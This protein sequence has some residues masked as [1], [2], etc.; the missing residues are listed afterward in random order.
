MFSLTIVIEVD[1]GTERPEALHLHPVHAFRRRGELLRVL[2]RRPSATA[3][4]WP[5]RERSADVYSTVECHQRPRRR[6]ERQEKTNHKLKCIFTLKILRNPQLSS[7]LRRRDRDTEKRTELGAREHTAQHL[8]G[9]KQAQRTRKIRPRLSRLSRAPLSVPWTLEEVDRSGERLERAPP[10]HR[11]GPQGACLTR[12]PVRRMR[13][14]PEAVSTTSLSWPTSSSMTA[15]SN[16]CCMYPA[17]NQP[18]SPPCSAVSQS[19]C[20]RASSPI[21]WVPRSMARFHERSS[22]VASA[23]VR[24]LMTSPSGSL[25]DA[26]R[27]EF[28]CLRRMCVARPMSC[29]RERPSSASSHSRCASSSGRSRAPT[30]PPP[31]RPRVA[32]RPGQGEGQGQLGSGS[33]GLGSEL[34]LG[35]GSGFRQRR[36]HLCRAAVQHERLC[37]GGVADRRRGAFV[38]QD[39]LPVQPAVIVDIALAL[40]DLAASL[41]RGLVLRGGERARHEHEQVALLCVAHAADAVGGDVVG[42]P[43]QAQ[44]RGV[45]QVDPEHGGR[46]L[47]GLGAAEAVREAHA[48]RRD[49]QGRVALR[50]A[51]LLRDLTLEQGALEVLATRPRAAPR[52]HRLRT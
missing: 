33:V 46:E 3:G 22:R 41:L 32:A 14:R 28:W 18:R 27:R 25:H 7:L 45:T 6:E 16:S 13:W 29:G 5:A 17:A 47:D 40:P 31:R 10:R 42:T 39:D 9:T 51:E 11:Q 19:E 30:P 4:H 26:S 38:E 44:R 52:P 49:S 23:C 15:S 24:C 37:R 43:H 21:S 34:G 2:R 48:A 1:Y 50:G 12:Q 36:D 35:S 8:R 20:S